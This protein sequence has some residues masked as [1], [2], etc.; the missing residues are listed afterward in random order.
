M[1]AVGKLTEITSVA[2]RKLSIGQIA[3]I[4]VSIGVVIMCGS[5]AYVYRQDE[6]AWIGSLFRAIATKIPNL[7]DKTWSKR[8]RSAPV[9]APEPPEP[10]LDPDVDDDG[11]SDL[12]TGRAE[13]SVVRGEVAVFWSCVPRGEWSSLMC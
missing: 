6:E 8:P 4:V 13:S 3:T 10:K 11:E 2:S 12:D 7:K 5:A 1:S 9:P